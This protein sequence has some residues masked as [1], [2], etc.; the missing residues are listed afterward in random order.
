MQF[1]QQEHHASWVHCMC[2]YPSGLLF[3]G[4]GLWTSLLACSCALLLFCAAPLYS[5]SCHTV[6]CPVL[7]CFVLCCACRALPCRAVLCCAVLCCTMLCRAVLAHMKL[8]FHFCA[9]GWEKVQYMSGKFPFWVRPWT[10]RAMR[11]K[12]H[13]RIFLQVCPSQ[14]ISSHDL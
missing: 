4:D 10:M 13:D 1:T 11:V 2:T 7:L 5:S 6:T 8:V 12:I 9:Q 14:L 3:C